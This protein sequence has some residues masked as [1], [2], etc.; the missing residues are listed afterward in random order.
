MP[1][2]PVPV[3]SSSTESQGPTNR[4]HRPLTVAAVMQIL[5]GVVIF[6]ATAGHLVPPANLSNLLLLVVI[7]LLILSASALLTREPWAWWSA[8]ATQV[9]LL[10]YELGTVLESTRLLSPGRA[11]IDRH[12]METAFAILALSFAMP[13][14]LCS[15]TALIYLLRP[16]TRASFGIRPRAREPFRIAPRTWCIALAVTLALGVLYVPARR[17]LLNYSLW[18][19]VWRNDAPGVS[20]LL[21]E[22]ADVEWREPRG[23]WTPL[24]AASYNGMDG[25]AQALLDAGAR[26]DAHDEESRTALTSAVERNQISLVKTLLARGADPNLQD[27]WGGTALATASTGAKAEIKKLLLAH[28]ANPHLHTEVGSAP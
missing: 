27:R 25:V 24:I 6:F 3:K 21:K 18:E 15:C 20:H 19:A 23:G 8:L 10:I 11:G 4:Q 13:L 14:T 22:G 28:G 26:V 9:P 2:D 5:V 16:R 1:A 12:G 7:G 17:V